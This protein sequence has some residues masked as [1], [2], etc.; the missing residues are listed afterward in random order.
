MGKCCNPLPGEPIISFI[1]RGHGLTIHRR[2]CKNVPQD[3]E[4]ASEPERWVMAHW[5]KDIKVEA[6]SS[7]SVWAINRDGVVLDITTALAGAH[8]KIHS[9]NARELGD[10]NCI[11]TMTIA[12]NGKEHLESIIKMLN[13]IQGVYLIERTDL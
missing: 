9:I 6:R 12:V 2:D 1:T 7:I 13:K 11:T 4:S 5:D 8:V 3:I 10:G